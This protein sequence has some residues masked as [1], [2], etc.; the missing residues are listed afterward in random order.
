MEYNILIGGS[1]GQGLDTL[2]DFLERSIKKFGFYVFSNKDYMSRVRGGHNFIQ[3]R[4]GENK[5]YSH[6][7][8]LD[9]ILAL[10]ENTISYHK[11]R[12]KDDGIIISDKSIKNEYKKI[13][14]L[15]LIETAKGLSLS[16]AF[17]SVA[18][19][20]ILKYF[21]I[22]L[23]NIDKYFSSKLSE[24]I[25]N[26]NIQAVKLGYDL[27]ESKHKM[28]GND[29]S[30]HILIN[31]NNAIALGAIA[32]GLDFYSAYPM[33]PAT[34]IMTYLAKKQ[35]ETGMVVDQAEDEIAA[36]NF[37]IG[38]SYAGARAMTGSSGGGVSLMV[39][40]FG[41][42]GITET[43]IVI[44][45]SQRP[46]PATGLPTRTEQSDL[47]FLLTAS[48]GEFPRILISVRN[49]EDA[50]YKTVKA[51]NLADKYQTVVILL[52]DQYLADSNITIPK[53][54]LNNIE[55]ER[56]ISNGEEL[57]EDE[58][59][60][61]YK[62]TQSGISPRM[63]PGNSKNQV[64]LV[65]SDEHTEESHITEEAE[66][67]NAQMEKRMK[68][69]E[70]IKKDIEEPEFIGK[71]DLEILLL[72]FGSTYGA[73]KD[74]V[75]ELNNQGEKVGALSFGD[76]YPLPE[77]G[78]RKYAK[79]A[80]I[81]INVEQNFTGQLGKLITQETGILMTYSILKYDGR[82]ICGNDIVARLR[83]EEF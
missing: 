23:E 7:N 2:S 57:K 49:A 1:A 55:I 69:L 35:V 17:T 76:I 74:A 32:G 20:V 13:I 26:K 5:I 27:I 6:K 18:A 82:Q 64:V 72:G 67:R 71:E 63:I 83:K 70:L 25:R 11:D 19:G 61:R 9:L 22:D 21:S 37:A 56:Y 66:V 33:T 14:K 12:L 75:E 43:P 44:V 45:D 47:S 62:V 24:D 78:L 54:N 46:G 79:Q 48:Q 40:A 52:T 31:G 10:D 80:K 29:L 73:L 16:K 58:E 41:L 4:F 51:L 60:K 8:E 36:I 42:A 81:I 28:Q 39:E 38:A 53:Y 50:F 77:E 65:D 15:P 30:D 3:I 59:Y 34:S 68:K